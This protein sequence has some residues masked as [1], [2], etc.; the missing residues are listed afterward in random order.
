M[1]GMRNQPSSELTLLEETKPL[2]VENETVPFPPS[3]PTRPSEPVPYLS[4]KSPP[5]PSI[6]DT[7][8]EFDKPPEV[9][10]KLT[11]PPAPPPPPS[12]P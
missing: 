5:N 2:K 12:P 7:V 3:L 9:V 4:P 6:A 1:S 11:K 8:P 10:I